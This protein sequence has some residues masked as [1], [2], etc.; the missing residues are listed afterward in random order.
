V[1][2]QI[3]AAVAPTPSP[4]GSNLGAEPDDP[5]ESGGNCPDGTDCERDCDPTEGVCAR[6]ASP[7]SEDDTAGV[8][9]PSMARV[10][11][12]GTLMLHPMATP[13]AVTTEGATTDGS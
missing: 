3:R 9:L 8:V 11:G 12:R 4:T 10:V 6:A 5:P 2:E 1:A 13:D 7:D